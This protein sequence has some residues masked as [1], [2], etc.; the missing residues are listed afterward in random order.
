M[1]FDHRGRGLVFSAAL[2]LALG[3]SFPAKAGDVMI[4]GAR[5]CTQQFP[6]A[7]RNYTIP[8]HLLAAISS[9]ETGRWHEGLGLALPWPWTINV[10]GQ[11]YY[12]KTK[13]EAIAQT[14]AL[15]RAGHQSIDVGCMQVNLKHHPHAFR[16][17][18]EAFDP[19][20]NVAYA[21]KFLRDN[22][23]ELGNWI[24]ATAAYHS[25]TPYYGQQYLTL[26]EKN[27]NRIVGKV[28]EARARQGDLGPIA[29]SNPKFD[30]AAVV[31]ARELHPIDDVHKM[32][33]IQ[34]KEQ[35]SR[36][37]VIVVR[38]PTNGP[39]KLADASNP[40]TD[41]VIVKG[42]TTGVKRISIDS[43]GNATNSTA[44]SSSANT[45]FVFAN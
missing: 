28:Q 20:T 40:A 45:K 29:G 2:A 3:F 18:D 16:T 14:A 1:G 35:P 32:R 6:V 33:I 5:L 39:I 15:L 11:G 26:I 34:V 10:D 21:A 41:E 25:R 9:T 44:T 12:F 42:T 37:E 24:K 36:N 4:E 8:T 23:S 7:E 13:G 22:Y 19:E 27:W 17:L 43:A 30:T 38:S 31:P